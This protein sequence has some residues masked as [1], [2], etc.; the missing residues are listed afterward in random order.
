ME[1]IAGIET[2]KSFRGF[3]P[4]PIP[5][6]TLEKILKTAGKSPSYT[7][8]QPWEVIVV[9]G[10]KRD[11][12]S[13]KLMELATTGTKPNP[14]LALP[15]SWPEALEKR[16]REHNIRRFQTLG[17]ERGDEQQRREMRLA[18]YK[19]YGAPCA[20]LLFM[21]SGLTQWSVFDM[22]LFA[23]TLILAAHS[24]G[25]GTCLQAALVHYPDAV[26]ELVNVPK[27]KELILGISIGYPDY[28]A[29]LN[30]YQS[31]RMGLDDFVR[32]EG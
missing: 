17:I 19:F 5:R 27:T 32:W 7:N 1:L 22:G 23:Q 8:T 12:L 21:E 25:L 15:A 20:L 30:S 10:K 18:N 4:T 13:K 9:T 28:D 2:R 11:E 31:L 26:R 6:E 14:A 29:K 24:F 16:S 3:K